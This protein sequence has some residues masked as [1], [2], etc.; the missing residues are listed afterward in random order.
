M[1]YRLTV[2]FNLIVLTAAARAEIPACQLQL[3]DDVQQGLQWSQLDGEN[4]YFDEFGLVLYHQK[5][6]L[7]G[8]TMAERG[9][10]LSR[11]LA[12]FP[13][14]GDDSQAHQLML[15]GENHAPCAL[16]ELKIL[17]AYD[18]GDI[19]A[20]LLALMELKF[21]QLASFT[22]HNYES[23]RQPFNAYESSLEA[24]INSLIYRFDGEG[25][26]DAIKAN[27]QEMAGS[28][29]SEVQQA[30]ATYHYVLVE[31]QMADQIFSQGDNLYS[32]SESND[33]AFLGRIMAA[34]RLLSPLGSAHAQ[35][36][37]LTVMQG[38]KIPKNAETLSKM[39]NHQLS[40]EINGKPHVGIFRDL[41]GL[42]AE[43]GF[44]AINL[45]AGNKAKHLQSAGELYNAAIA[46]WGFADK[47]MAGFFPNE[48]VDIEVTYGPNELNIYE[49][50]NGSV[51][52]INVTPQAP[53]IDLAT[54]MLGTA[55]Q[56]MKVQQTLG[57]L[58]A[59]PKL[60]NYL[61]QSKIGDGYQLLQI[62]A[63]VFPKAATA[64]SETVSF[65]APWAAD[66]LLL[67]KVPKSALNVN[68]FKY[69]PVNIMQPG[70]FTVLSKTTDL[71]GITARSEVVNYHA[72]ST[73]TAKLLVHS[74]GAKFANAQIE[75]IL[76]VKINADDFTLTP[77]LKASAFGQ[78][79]QLKL[80]TFAQKDIT[81]FTLK[82][83]DGMKWVSK[84]LIG[85]EQT[86]TKDEVKI[87]A[88]V[89]TAPLNKTQFPATIEASRKGSSGSGQQATLVLPKLVPELMCIEPGVSYRFDVSTVSQNQT[90]ERNLDLENFAIQVDG[91]GQVSEHWNY[92]VAESVVE[93]NTT[94]QLIDRKDQ[95]I[96]DEATVAIGC[97]CQ[98]Q[99]ETD[100]QQSVGI[101]ALWIENI[102]AARPAQ[103]L[104]LSDK[105]HINM[106]QALLKNTRTASGVFTFVPDCDEG[107][108]SGSWLSIVNEKAYAAGYSPQ[109]EGDEG[110]PGTPEVRLNAV[111]DKFVQG[112]IHGAMVYGNNAFAENKVT[113][114]AA[115]ISA[116]KWLNQPLLSL[117]LADLNSDPNA[118]AG[119]G[120]MM[121]QMEAF[122]V[123]GEKEE[124][125]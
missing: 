107:T 112:S 106:H 96:Y 121:S 67:P 68:P 8:A 7:T 125:Q 16:G 28:N 114:T 31:S 10:E 24:L 55:I 2:L 60:T 73:G 4:N 12:L 49:N 89:V 87:Y 86:G 72:V 39:M 119:L 5:G 83:A 13:L 97:G 82:L 90:E 29:D 98:W 120:V 69:P 22:E 123:C 92:R 6:Q 59:R 104:I 54:V 46:L 23:Y 18:V 103:L 58:A 99:A 108:V 57:K 52:E 79:H 75:T 36:N 65:T 101:D 56:S 51:D 70:Y 20:D 38:V 47:L 109:C 41:S 94:I 105:S 84:S 15:V 78:T 91:P 64:T 102:D 40:S 63:Y 85:T 95:A 76:D 53:G 100:G 110:N 88:L 33:E 37:G 35:L 115:R 113:F 3:F 30:L 34:M 81:D 14:A 19:S 27:I 9:A 32:Q 62:M 1:P 17:P 93:K 71:L 25:N 111:S 122:S 44:T 11:V 80:R 74:N 117:L 48:L 26:P 124:V 50:K 66:N 21:R 42:V 118:L 116:E 77:Q 45:A 43:K 61:M